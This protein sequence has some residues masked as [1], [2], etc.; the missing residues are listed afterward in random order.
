MGEHGGPAKTIL[1]VE[2]SRTQ[3]EYLTHILKK[4]GFSSAIAE[5]GRIALEMVATERPAVILTDIIMPEMD[6]YELCRTIRQNPETATLPVIMVTQLFDPAD[7]L[8]GLEAGADNFIIK[9]FDSEI[10][11]TGITEALAGEP[12]SEQGG[13]S[14]VLDVEFSGRRYAIRVTKLRILKIL[15]STYAL[16]IRKNA[17][18][19]EAQER[20]LAV[21][22]Q[23]QQMVE[24]LQVANEDLQLE[25][26][27]R[28]KMERDLAQAN[29]K[30]QLMTSITRHD[31]VN[32]LTV[33]QG[34]LELATLLNRT[35]PE[36]AEGYIQKSLTVV[37][38]TV[39][40]IQFTREYQ[41]IG[42]TSPVWNDLSS[43][44][45]NALKYTTLGD[46][47]LEN[48][49]PGGVEI[50]AD[51]LIEKVIFNLIDNALR[52]GSTLTTIRFRIGQDGDMPFI[53]CEDDGVGIPS[54]LKD[55]IFSYAFGSNTG[56]GLFLVRE[57]LAITDITIRETGI[58][59][60]GARFEIRPQPKGIRMP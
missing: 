1:V 28:E 5:N 26:A 51:P 19:Q 58:P 48:E 15:L 42:V 8:R 32:Q 11:Y 43:S 57:I 2:D 60:Q 50:L 14:P 13:P 27:A 56:M 31:L 44:I 54:D 49:I 22:E 10:V 46:V 35:D 39:G 30:L 41:R 34:Y 53:V 24:E 20:L 21:N 17:D 18:L 3:A 4:G 45:R 16:A 9:P 29:K 59:G 36:K 52:Y 7:I 47:V 37:E 55:R 23:L 25:N 40:T 38:K 12:G 33:L 6:G